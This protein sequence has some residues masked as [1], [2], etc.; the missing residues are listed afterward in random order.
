MPKS[1]PDPA[2][3][4]FMQLAKEAGIPPM[5]ELGVQGAREG[6]LAGRVN[7]I[8]PPAVAR[9]EDR[10]IPG[11]A[12]EVPVRCYHPPGQSGTPGVLLYFHGGGFVIGD[13]DTHDTVCR[14]LCTGAGV[15]VLSVDYRLAPDHPFPA[16]VADTKTAYPAAVDDALAAFDW[17][18]ENAATLG[19]DPG[20]MAV[21]GD[22]AGGTLAAFVAQEARDRGVPLRAQILNYPVVDLARRYPSHDEHAATPPISE[23]VL[24]WFWSQ[25]L[26]SDWKANT[27][28]LQ[29]PRIS[30]IHTASFQGLAPAYVLTAG[31]D[32]L[33]DEGEAYAQAL[34]AAGVETV[35]QC[36]MGTI[37][38]FL[39]LGRLIPTAGDAMSGAAAFLAT[40]MNDDG[41]TT[42]T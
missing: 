10:S 32:P 27:Q 16:A 17:L 18:V 31:L 19:A 36:V 14:S 15:M 22:S 42:Q 6:L 25:Y 5:H 38:G 40:R 1:P 29:D 23:P 35:Y 33:R 20:R 12:G 34:A 7:D 4:R 21:G 24:N 41:G 13:L 8:D 9:V 30:P 26:G 2:T 3:A 39:R 28:R 37:H 11:P